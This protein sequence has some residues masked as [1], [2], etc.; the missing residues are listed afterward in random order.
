LSCFSSGSLAASAAAPLKELALTPTIFQFAF[1]GAWRS[2]QQWSSSFVFL[3]LL[4]VLADRRS[5]RAMMPAQFK[6]TLL[7]PDIFAASSDV[8]KVNQIFG[9]WIHRTIADRRLTTAARNPV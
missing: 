5:E 1:G 2:C 3:I 9:I 6:T 7:H 4:F 8:S